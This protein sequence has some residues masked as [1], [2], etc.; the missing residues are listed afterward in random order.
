MLASLGAE[1]IKLRKRPSTW[2][3]GSIWL[4]VTILLSYA[5]AYALLSSVPPPTVPEDTPKAQKAQIREQQQEL[6][7]HQLEFLYPEN[8]VSY[9]TPGFPN[10]GAPIALILGA[11]AVGSEYGWATFKTVLTQ[12]P[13]RYALFFGK[14]LALGIVLAL[15]VVLTFAAGAASGF[16]IA[17]L[18]DASVGLPAAGELVRALGAGGLILAIWAALG[19]LL[20]TLLRSTALSIGLGLVYSFV[21]ET[22][23]FNL[24]IES[25]AFQD[26]REFFPGQNSNF[27]AD[28][29]S[30]QAHGGFVPPEPPV[31]APQAALVLLAYTTAFIVLAAFVFSRRDVD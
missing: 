23:I 8:L 31:D 15:L 30:E 4:A 25:K 5:L 21:L 16:V 10:L 6:E 13:G 9:L 29:F 3:L 17:S 19:V 27:L 26:A 28:S 20:A 12:R 14:L 11:L 1:F 24:P 2:V 7:E 22:I 18:E